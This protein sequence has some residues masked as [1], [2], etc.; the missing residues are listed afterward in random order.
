MDQVATERR[1]QAVVEN[2]GRGWPLQEFEI[3]SDRFD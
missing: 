2:G 3:P 1:Q